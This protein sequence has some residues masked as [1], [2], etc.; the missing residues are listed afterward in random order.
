MAL[1]RLGGMDSALPWAKGSAELPKAL[2][3]LLKVLPV[4]PVPPVLPVLPVLAVLGVLT[5]VGPVTVP[6]WEQNG[7]PAMAPLEPSLEAN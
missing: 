5:A 6:T 1:P 3:V 2:P 4:L 7:S